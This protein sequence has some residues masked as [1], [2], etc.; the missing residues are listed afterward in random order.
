MITIIAA[1]SKNRVIGKDNSLIWRLPEDLKRFK[2]LT[3]GRNVLM[4]R[5]T[6]ESIGKPLPNRTNIVVTRDKSYKKEGIL[7]YN[8]YTE[9]LPI[10]RDIVVIGGGEIY[11]QMI[12]FAD[13][14]ELTLIDKEFDGDTLF[15]IIDMNQW[16]EVNRE[17]NN[18][19]E[20]DYHF[21]TY[22]RK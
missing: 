18:N 16:G 4:G 9:V 6:F 17:S 2:S 13:I 3:T 1:C 21:I 11:Q 22:K 15:P 10:F 14:I 20:F 5:K 19:G 8:S 12:Q 7:V